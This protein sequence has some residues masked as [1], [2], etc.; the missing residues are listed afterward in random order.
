M[1]SSRDK[2]RF[3]RH[4]EKTRRFN[5]SQSIKSLENTPGFHLKSH[6]GCALEVRPHPKYNGKFEKDPFCVKSR[7]E[8]MRRLLSPELCS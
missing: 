5:S 1:E 2:Q 8:K 6:K 3:Q 7:E 4:T